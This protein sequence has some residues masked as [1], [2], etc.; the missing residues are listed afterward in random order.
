VEFV[1]HTV[2]NRSSFPKPRG[3]QQGVSLLFALMSLVILG[4]AAVA[5]TRSVD[6]GVLI[7][8]NLS[9]K[10]DTLVAGSSGAEQAISWLQANINSGL[11]DS[12]QPANGYYSARSD[13]LDP[14]GGQTS[15][16]DP[17]PLVNWDGSCQ[18]AVTG[19]YQNCDA[20]SFSGTAVNGNRIKWVITRLCDGPG[21][22][23]GTNLCVRPANGTMASAKER[24]ELTPGGR[25]TSAVAGPF[26]RVIVR[27]DG[28]RNTV[29]YTESLVHF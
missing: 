13:K 22:A 19:T 5:L 14:T 7:M 16:A 18:G 21:P 28:P 26:F 6:T 12:D 11:L 27:I 20:L 2:R 8:G 24:G 29:S 9:F 23:A 15:T 17:R 3:L 1:R 10:Q 4:F 25:I